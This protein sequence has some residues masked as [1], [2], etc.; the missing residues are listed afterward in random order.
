MLTT[1]RKRNSIN[2]E[3]AIN[4]AICFQRAA[5]QL[6]IRATI[7]IQLGMTVDALDAQRDAAIFAGASADI[8]HCVLNGLIR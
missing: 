5:A 4:D 8:L 7:C 2:L 6:H 3:W 1:G